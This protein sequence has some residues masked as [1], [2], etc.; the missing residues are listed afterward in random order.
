MKTRATDVLIYAAVAVAVAVVGLWGLSHVLRTREPSA[1]L[2]RAT[3]EALR[4][5][6]EARRDAEDARRASSALRVLSLVVGVSVPLVVAYLIFRLKARAEPGA[7]E[8]LAALEKEGLL[9]PPARR[10]LWPGRR[11]P[12]LRGGT[13]PPPD[14]VPS[15]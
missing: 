14:D 2:A 3:R 11:P 4:M 13:E 5:A 9:G 15:A 1:E 7:E 10:A 12:M 6:R 8:I